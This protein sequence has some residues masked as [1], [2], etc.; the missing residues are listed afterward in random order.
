MR[1]LWK[2]HQWTII[3]VL[4]VVTY[5]LGL[6]GWVLY[7]AAEEPLLWA[8]S[9]FPDVLYRSLTLFVMEGAGDLA[10]PPWQLDVARF[11]APAIVVY[12]AITALFSAFR[13][14]L[15][16]FHA[17]LFSDHV[18]VCGLGEKG[19]LIA[20]ALRRAGCRVIVVEFDAANGRIEEARDQGIVVL[21][22]NATD[23]E[24]LAGAGIAR[25]SH[26]FA[27]A[28]DDGVNAEVA[29]HARE[30]VTRRAR[31]R[32]L[33]C[34]IHISDPDLAVFLEERS[35]AETQAAGFRLEVFNIH[36]SGARALLR[37]FPPWVAKSPR[38]AVVG[39]G[40]LS[41]AFIVETARQWSDP[42]AQRL[43]I[44]LIDRDAAAIARD[45][46][47]RFPIVAERCDL[48]T[49]DC[50]PTGSRCL[51]GSLLR[52]ESGAVDVSAVYICLGDDARSLS[53]ALGLRRH[54]RQSGVP[55]IVRTQVRG[56]LANLVGA[57][58]RPVDEGAAEPKIDVF[59]LYDRTC[60]P[61]ILMRSRREQIAR[62]I[63]EGYL[64]TNRRLYGDGVPA[65]AA[66]KPWEELPEHYREANRAQADHII[67]KLREIGCRLRHRYGPGAPPFR[68]TTAELETL[69][70]AEHERWMQDRS[71]SGWRLG[72]QRDERKKV[73]PDLVDWD[74]LAE[75]RRELDRDAVRK[76]PAY[77]A[78]GGFEI[79]R[80][81]AG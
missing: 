28:G 60:V 11:A 43:P 17:G 16:M 76:L 37:D 14:Q 26:V 15:Q 47:L 9:S 30:A 36:E 7:L 62:A 59:S 45:L 35:I 79:V 80:E 3:A 25:A 61:E 1:R 34:Y 49:I 38:P 40:R 13:A 41:R 42:G 52:D 65:T 18:V 39:A 53:A 12:T 6:W 51:E 72:S 58:S 32:G 71:A 56:G 66:V 33:G 81:A 48:Q 69:A 63:H 21:I 20:T 46:E 64:A 2:D 57:Q 4:A 77:L 31:S 73:H 67:P 22:G 70:R 19:F 50:D 23:R 10:G 54:I 44:L 68:F 24:R 78:T 74:D 55:F 75:D 29:V 27:V 8:R 5:G